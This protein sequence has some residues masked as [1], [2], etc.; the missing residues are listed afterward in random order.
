M[1]WSWCCFVSNFFMGENNCFKCTFTHLL[2]I[3]CFVVLTLFFFIKRTGG[4]KVK[5]EFLSPT[6]YK[7]LYFAEFSC[8][9]AEQLCNR[10]T[11]EFFFIVYYLLVFIYIEFQC[12]HHLMLHLYKEIR[13]WELLKFKVWKSANH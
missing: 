10:M 7:C 13:S 9:L 4:Y 6:R 2:F 12:H 5:G 11:T 1:G 8:H 3:L